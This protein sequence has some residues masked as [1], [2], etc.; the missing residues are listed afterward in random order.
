MHMYRCTSCTYTYNRNQICTVLVCRNDDRT[1]ITVRERIFGSYCIHNMFCKKFTAPAEVPPSEGH[2]HPGDDVVLY[3]ATQ[4][5]A[6][7]GDQVL[8][9]GGDWRGGEGGERES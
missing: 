8:V 6:I 2:E 5:S 3:Q 1:T 9:M 7:L 4:R